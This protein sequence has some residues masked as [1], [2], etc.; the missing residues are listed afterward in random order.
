MSSLW[1][2]I[3]IIRFRLRPVCSIVG[4][5]TLSIT[6]RQG[7]AATTWNIGNITN[8]YPDLLSG[9]I[10]YDFLQMET[11]SQIIIA[12]PP[13]AP[14]GLTA[15]T[16]SGCEIDLAWTNNATNATS[17]VIQRSTDGVNF[18]QIGAVTRTGTNYADT[19]LPTG[20]T[21]YYQVVANNAD[22][23]SPVSNTAHASTQAAQPPAAPGGLTAIAIS[24]NQIN[25]TWIDNSTNEDGFNLERSTDGGN[26][27]SLAIVAAGITN[28]SDTGLARRNAPITIK[29]RRF[30]RAGAIP[31][32]SAR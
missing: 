9:G 24:T 11:G 30:V 29:S 13:L 10:M 12:N 32:T 14:S 5:N 15:T 16:V 6:I 7:G 4:T 17:I 26:Y 8:G 3:S 22:G 19:S 31:P 20:T 23:N 25:L 27:S 1:D 2:A 18:S 28:Y 21:Y